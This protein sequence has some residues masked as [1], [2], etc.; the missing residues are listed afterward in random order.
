MSD[1]KQLSEKN[2][3]TGK[4][5]SKNEKKNETVSPDMVKPGMI[6]RVHEKINDIDAKG[7]ERARIQI[8]EGTVIAVKKPK[9]AEGSIVVRK[10]SDASI[11]VEKI[12]PLRSPLIEKIEIVRTV[13]TRRAKLYYLRSYKKRLKY[14]K[15]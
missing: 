6:L 1:N 13:K 7:K 4:K 12:F 8:F 2:I 14:K 9:T 10:I 15:H 11:G 5:P 3:S